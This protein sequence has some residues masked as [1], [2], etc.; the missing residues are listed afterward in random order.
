MTH[1]GHSESVVRSQQHLRGRSNSV[2]KSQIHLRGRSKSVVITY[3][4]RG[5]NVNQSF[6]APA[7]LAI[8]WS[9]SHY[10]RIKPV[11]H[12]SRLYYV[13]LTLVLRSF[14][15]TLAP[16]LFLTCQKLRH[17]HDAHDDCTT[18][19]RD[20]ST[21]IEDRTAFLPRS[22][23]FHHALRAQ[24]ERSEIVAWCDGGLTHCSMH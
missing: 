18:H 22:V 14:F 6:H 19:D 7:T 9:R 21:L 12:L 13:L 4:H 16:R 1:H 15:A 20:R 24:C 2:D 17:A 3:W 10:A 11:L 8:R 23:R 5:E